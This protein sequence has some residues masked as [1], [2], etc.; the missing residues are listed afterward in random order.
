[1]LGYNKDTP[2]D[3]IQWIQQG[4]EI[5]NTYSGI[6]FFMVGEK[7]NM[8][9]EWLECTNTDNLTYREFIGYCDI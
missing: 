4:C 8:P 9:P 3:N 5:F 6:K 2:A 7:T 1:M